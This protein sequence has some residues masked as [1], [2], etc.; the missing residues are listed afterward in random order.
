[1]GN[2][3]SC[4]Q[5]A[6]DCLCREAHKPACVTRSAAAHTFLQRRPGAWSVPPAVRADARWALGRHVGRA[7][8]PAIAG[9]GALPHRRR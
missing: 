3:A 7:M 2:V 6:V 1:M 8:L 9:D 5:A 4:V